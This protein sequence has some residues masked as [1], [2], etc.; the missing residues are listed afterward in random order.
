MKSEITL[1]E[2]LQS[3]DLGLSDLWDAL[4]E[5]E[6]KKLKLEFYILL[7]Y[8]S[9]ISK[10]NSRDKK[11]HFVLTVN[12]Y[13]NKHFFDLQNH[14]KLLWQLF[15]LCNYNSVSTFYH[16]WIPSLKRTL[17][18]RV[19]LLETIFPHRKIDE[20]ELINKKLS[21]TDFINLCKS[22]GMTDSE[23]KKVINT[24]HG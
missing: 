6:Q 16:E 4:P 7:R 15:C 8:V 17:N 1:N 12:E 13:C 3:I 21:E 14:P 2:K 20:L 24:Y 10:S 18:K 19:Q 9:N 22:Y 23:I 5:D 11:E